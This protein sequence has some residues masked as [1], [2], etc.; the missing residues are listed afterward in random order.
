MKI[1]EYLIAKSKS[2]KA[3]RQYQK[4]NLRTGNEKQEPVWVVRHA[5]R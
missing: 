3:V 5:F 2:K 4:L 1:S